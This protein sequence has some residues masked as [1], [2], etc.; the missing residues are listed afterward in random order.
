MILFSKDAL[1]ALKEESFAEGYRAG[2]ASALKADRE[3]VESV[4]R[5]IEPKQNEIYQLQLQIQAQRGTIN[6]LR[7]ALLHHV[8]ETA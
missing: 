5:A 1:Q 4:Q 8:K 3:Y 2:L 6:E 7:Q